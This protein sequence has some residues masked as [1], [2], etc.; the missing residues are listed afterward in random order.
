MKRVKLY[1]VLVGVGLFVGVN[2]GGTVS[3]VTTAA[4]HA[5]SE[6]CAELR[7]FDADGVWCRQ[8]RR[9]GHQ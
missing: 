8:Y 1:A 7:V 2:P 6:R 3:G 4:Q 9:V 5:R